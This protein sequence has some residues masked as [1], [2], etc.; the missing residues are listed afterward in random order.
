VIFPIFPR[1]Y[2]SFFEFFNLDFLTALHTSDLGGSLAV[3]KWRD[4]VSV[5]ISMSVRRLSDCLSPVPAY[6]LL[7][8]VTW[9]SSDDN[10]ICYVLPVFIPE[11]CCVEKCTTFWATLYMQSEHGG[12]VC[13]PR[14]RCFCRT[15]VHISAVRSIHT[16]WAKS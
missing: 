2:C 6:T 15:S 12:K 3:Y 7:L 1:S 4:G 10:T 5:A 14:L 13:H 16:G 9:S 11:I 8:A